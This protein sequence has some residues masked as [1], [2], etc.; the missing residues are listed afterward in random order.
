M[1]GQARASLELGDLKNAGVCSIEF[2]KNC[3]AHFAFWAPF[4]FVAEERVR[5]REPVC[6][7]Y[8]DRGET[9]TSPH[10]AR[11]ASVRAARD[12]NRVKTYFAFSYG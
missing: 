11:A 4:V 2:G 3:E 1:R 5:G 6:L 9:G 7:R 12:L 8:R 10:D